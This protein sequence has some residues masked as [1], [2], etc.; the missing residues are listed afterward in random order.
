MHSSDSTP[1]TTGDD[2]VDAALTRLQDLDT[3]PV[4]E[5]IGVFEAVHGAL[6]ERLAD[7]EQGA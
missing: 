6:Q 5:H 1:P 2:G 3:L 4:R 7:T